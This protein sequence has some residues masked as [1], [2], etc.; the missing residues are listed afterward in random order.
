VCSICLAI[1]ASV[2]GQEFPTEPVN[3]AE[4]AASSSTDT[5]AAQ[6]SSW[7]YEEVRRLGNA[8]YR[9]RQAARS[10]LE[11]RP[12]E[13]LQVIQ[14]MIKQVD[15]VV[16]LQLVD[17]LSGLAMHS[18]IS[19]SGIATQTLSTT[20]DN[21]TSVGRAAANSLS[22]IADLQE[23]RACQVLT[24]QGA[25]IGPQNFSINGRLSNMEGPLS[26]RI[27][28]QFTGRDE[29]FEWIRYLKTIKVVY[30]RGD[31]ITPSA[32]EAVSQLKNV[33]AI[34]LRSIRLTREQL[35]LFQDLHALE[36]LGLSYMD[37]D[38]SFI[39][40]LMQLPISHSIRLY[41]TKVTAFGEQQLVQQFDGL[42]IFRG[43]GGFLG[44]SSLSTRQAQVE[45]VTPDSAASRAGIQH[46]DIITAI[47]ETAI[48]TFEQLRLELG[49][50]EADETVSVRLT[51]FVYNRLQ[52]QLQQV[53]LTVKATLQ[54]ESN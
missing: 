32:I 22:A 20:A 35:L 46:G 51:R 33:Q 13:S 29:D 7:A 1:G 8:S 38:D 37:V 12:L 14:Q 18:D 10:Q 39:P 42:E 15:V 2:R 6:R 11:E 53:E 41:G 25:Y 50:Y 16:G 52:D 17:L 36:H 30:L 47:N 26:L 54:E 31:K 19:V 24:D 23:E 3:P 44:I 4:S 48:G 45:Q 40:N 5:E 27:D 34:K 21:A 28:D 49:K 9:A 43:S